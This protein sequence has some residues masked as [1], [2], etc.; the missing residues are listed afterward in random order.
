MRVLVEELKMLTGLSLACGNANQS[1]NF[2]IGLAREVLRSDNGFVP[3]PFPINQR[4]LFD[5]ASLTKLFCAIAVLQLVEAGKLSFTDN[6][7]E[8][9]SRFTN[10]RQATLYEVLTYQAVLRSPER[11]DEQPD[12]LS[13]KAQVFQIYLDRGPEPARLYSDMNALVLKYLVETAS[14]LAFSDYLQRH[15]LTPCGMVETYAQVPQ[16]RLQDCLNYNY[17]HHMMA[18]RAVLLDKVMPGL[19]HDPKARLL[20]ENGR[21]LAGHAGLF[22]SL[23][24]MVRLAQGM[25]QGVI[26]SPG[27]LHEMGRNRTGRYGKDIRYRQYLGYLCFSKSADQSLSEVPAFMG[28]RAIGLSGYTG[29]HFALDPELGVFDIFLGNRCHNRVALIEPA[30]DAARYHL[31]PEGAGQIPWPDGRL[32]QSSWRYVHQ[33]DRLLHTPCYHYLKQEGWLAQAQATP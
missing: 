9:D 17:E 16:E 19:P 3:S 27:M 25:L 11:I 29:N 20:S 12:A 23:Q 21:D 14:G 28:E 15:I 10:L 8:M 6:V 7:G 5:L 31:S 2:H 1:A 18:G 4:S 13:A 22:S 30:Q 33:K 26:L 32:V 24:D